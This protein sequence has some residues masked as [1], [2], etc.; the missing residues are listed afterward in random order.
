MAI[1]VGPADWE[2]SRGGEGGTIAPAEASAVTP[3]EASAVTPAPPSA[4][5]SDSIPL[6]DVALD[7]AGPRPMLVRRRAFLFSPTQLAVGGTVLGLIALASILV[8]VIG[9]EPAERQRFLQA[10]SGLSNRFKSATSRPAT[11][12]AKKTEVAPSPTAPNATAPSAAI[13]DVPE[14]APPPPFRARDLASS[15]EVKLVSGAIDRRTF[16]DALTE[17]GIPRA[18]TYRLLAAFK[19]AH[20]LEHPRRHDSFVAAL[21]APTRRVRAFEY[22]VSPTEVYQARERDDHSLTVEKLDLHV[23]RRRALAAVVL[24]DDMAKSLEAAGLDRSLMDW[25]DDALEGRAEL[26]RLRAGSRFRL[27]AEYETVS[28]AFARYTDLQAIEY[29]PLDE[30]AS[31]RVYHFHED[32]TQGYFDATGRQPYKGAFRTPVLFSHITSRFNMHRMHPILHVVMPHNGV[33]FAAPSGT[34]VY[35]ASAGSIEWVGNAGASGN[36]ITIR[37]GG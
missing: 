19:G 28:G 14:P 11:S 26:P 30:T 3:A 37:H 2:I 6:L 24:G 36:L 7:P 34:P 23:E 18:Q 1:V 10:W 31:L 27:V 15:P 17:A 13:I 9:S 8:A 32:K 4:D 12:I 35:A 20:D 21:D 16:I 25:L 22:E 5:R 33:D 29:V